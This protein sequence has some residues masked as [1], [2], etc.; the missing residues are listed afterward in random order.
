[1]LL[2]NSSSILFSSSWNS[3]TVTQ[4]WH[5]VPRQRPQAVTHLSPLDRQ[6]HFLT[7]LDSCILCMTFRSSS[8]PGS[9]SAINGTNEAPSNIHPQS[10]GSKVLSMSVFHSWSWKYTRYIWNIAACSVGGKLSGF[11]FAAD[12]AILIYFI[13]LR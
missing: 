9:W 10:Y 3:S 8:G 13:Y 11:T 4:F 12:E 7:L 2:S 1:M 6:K 5:S